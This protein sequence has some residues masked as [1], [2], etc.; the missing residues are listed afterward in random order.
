MEAWADP[1]EPTREQA[2]EQH[3]INKKIFNIEPKAGSLA[4]GE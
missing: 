1:G 3:V 4:P 2:F